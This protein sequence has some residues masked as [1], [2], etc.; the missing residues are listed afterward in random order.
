MW[1]T[2]EKQ[3]GLKMKRNQDGTGPGAVSYIHTLNIYD[4]I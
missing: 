4:M 3:Q 2:Q 1:D